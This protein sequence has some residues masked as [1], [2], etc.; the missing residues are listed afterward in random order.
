M[1]CLDKTAKSR[2]STKNWSWIHFS[3]KSSSKEW[4]NCWKTTRSHKREETN[5]ESSKSFAEGVVNISHVREDSPMWALRREALALTSAGMLCDSWSS[6]GQATTALIAACGQPLLV[7]FLN[8]SLIVNSKIISRVL[9]RTVLAFWLWSC[10]M[11]LWKL[12]A[13]FVLYYSPS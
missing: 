4:R 5:Q 7:Y 13:N 1:K 10:W 9:I 3:T 6:H 8:S 12:N 2:V 11:S